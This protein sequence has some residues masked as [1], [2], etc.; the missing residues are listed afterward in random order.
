M[1]K[2]HQNKVLLSLQIEYEPN[3]VRGE[4]A[5]PI[6]HVYPSNE[7]GNDYRKHEF[8]GNA[9]AKIGVAIVSTGVEGKGQAFVEQDSAL[10]F[11]VFVDT[12][13]STG[14]RST[15]L[16]GSNYIFINDLLNLGINNYITQ[17][18][19]VWNAD[20]AAKNVGASVSKGRIHVKLTQISGW[21]QPN[22]STMFKPSNQF[23]ASKKG[24]SEIVLKSLNEYATKTAQTFEMIPA[25][26]DSIKALPYANLFWRKGQWVALGASYSFKRPIPSDLK[27]W[28]NLSKAAL[29]RR[30]PDM[31][32]EESTKLFMQSSY[33]NED[34]IML[35]AGI[36]NTIYVN[37][38]TYLADGVLA[39]KHSALKDTE[40]NS[41]DHDLIAH[42][43]KNLPSG[44]EYISMENFSVNMYAQGNPRTKTSASGDCEDSATL[45]SISDMDLLLRTDLTSIPVLKKIQECRKKY[46]FIKVLSGVAGQQLSDGA[47]SSKNS[48]YDNQGGHMFGMYLPRT[49]FIKY[50]KRFNSNS[51]PYKGFLDGIRMNNPNA[52]IL[53]IEGT[54]LLHP[55]G[56][57]DP[58]QANEYLEPYRYI[59]KKNDPKVSSKLSTTKFI[60]PFMRN[61]LN[62]FYRTILTFGS[63]DLAEHYATTETTVVRKSG[64][65]KYKIGCTF[66]EFINE[67]AKMAF[68]AAPEMTETEILANRQMLRHMPPII[69]VPPARND[70]PNRIE[71][72]E[73]VSQMEAHI[74][75]LNRRP[76]PEKIQRSA[77]LFPS[78]IHLNKDYLE[79][80][81]ILVNEKPNIYDVEFVEQP[82]SENSWGY[83]FIYRINM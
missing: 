44:V 71:C 66:E 45:A 4:E 59:F 14:E 17:D 48:P 74:K 35:V 54:G 34:D 22:V 83:Q 10:H 55:M 39:K 26:W 73:I 57:D 61:K 21:D 41:L 11:S 25:K 64:D 2:I 53:V 8:R 42:D 65:G 38:A 6:L 47:K 24:V 16:A 50:H 75:S 80:F 19:V 63:T 18:L 51:D 1:S 67:S 62:D 7:L 81:K 13:N 79:A 27:V 72:K 3:L 37:W 46:M 5:N 32:V 70:D 82:I 31:S 58:Q 33:N 76:H 28:K 20:Q 12:M 52:K 78:Y 40:L 43:S 29:K 49:K 56:F 15:G 69:P 77:S 9:T 60:S 68:I 23:T 30:F 36:M